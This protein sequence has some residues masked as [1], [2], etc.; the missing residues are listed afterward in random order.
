MIVGAAILII[1][2][3]VSI[4]S[5]MDY[6]SALGQNGELGFDKPAMMRLGAGPFPVPDIGANI[7]N[8]VVPLGDRFEIGN[9]RDVPTLS[10]Q[11]LEN[12][13][14]VPERKPLG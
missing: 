9:F 12:I 13:V 3:A 14:P 5:A 1:A 2:A 11:T 7:T 10:R 8:A 6:S 4:V